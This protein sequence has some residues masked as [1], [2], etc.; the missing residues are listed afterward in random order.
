[1]ALSPNDPCP[2]GSGRKYKNCHQREDTV[3]ANNGDT[4]A[5]GRALTWLVNRHGHAFD[6]ALQDLS[7]EVVYAAVGVD[8]PDFD[9]QVWAMFETALCES[10][11]ADGELRIQGRRVR[12]IDLLLGRGGPLMTTGQRQFLEQLGAQPLQLYQVTDVVVGE[13]ITLCD[14][15]D[16][17]APPVVVHEHLGSLSMKPGLL[18][19]CRVLTLGGRREL[20][21]SLVPF[22]A[23]AAPGAIDAARA[24][25]ERLAQHAGQNAGRR[26]EAAMSILCQWLRQYAGGPRMPQL[27]DA[28]S[29]GTMLLITDHYDVHDEAALAAALESCDD[30]SSNN[31]GGWHREF[32]GDDGLVRIRVAINRSGKPDRLELFYRTQSYADEGR[33]WFDA[34]AGSAVRYLTREITD[35]RAILE[36]AR[37]GAATVAAAEPVP[38]SSPEALADAIEQVL[39][40]SYANWA[41]ESVPALGGKTPRQAAASAAGQER[42][43]G[44]LRSYDASEEQAAARQ[45]RRAMSYQ[46]LWDALGLQ[47]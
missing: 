38:A 1:M 47:R 9:D 3:A 12:T 10:T 22:S 31:A 43:K 44:L 4:G 6:K 5:V 36:S 18:L 35:P 26:S 42:V 21:G 34:L 46:F 40:R 33:P 17:E 28:S 2:C 20:S 14:A 30:V 8:A 19:G 41:D 39:R 37:T 24:A 7:S 16:A 13:S 32:T 45:G 27:V 29:G 11:L 15:L 23:L 25:L